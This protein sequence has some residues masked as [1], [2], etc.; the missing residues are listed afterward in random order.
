MKQKT[1]VWVLV[2]AGLM[3]AASAAAIML[4]GSGWLT[5]G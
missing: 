4:V 3:L 5:G 1:L 2:G